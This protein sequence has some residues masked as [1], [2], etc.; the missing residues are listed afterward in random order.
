[1]SNRRAFVANVGLILASVVGYTLIGISP[2]WSQ[3]VPAAVVQEPAPPADQQYT[4]SKQCAACHFDQFMKWK[5][6]KHAKTFDLLP[7]QYQA[8]AKCLACHTTGYGRATGFT[9]EAAS[10]DL[11]GT[12]CEACHG[13]GSKHAEIAKQFAN[14]KLTPEQEK[15]VRDS[16]WRILPTNA[17]ISCHVLQ[18]HHDNPTPPELRKTK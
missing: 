8:D 2:A 14:M 18:G 12:S 3:P 9:T 17:C 10:P 7:A 1:M 4:G 16:I 6:T 5:T 13:P 11:K 15:T